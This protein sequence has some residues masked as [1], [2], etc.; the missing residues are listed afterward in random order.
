MIP[1]RALSQLGRVIADNPE[2]GRDARLRG[3]VHELARDP[4]TLVR[5]VDLIAKEARKKRPDDA[6]MEA[7]GFLLG[8]GLEVVRYGVERRSAQEVATAA[9]VRSHIAAL[10][11]KGGLAPAPVL[12]VLRRF[13]AAKL[14]LGEDLTALMAEVAAAPAPDAGAED[15]DHLFRGLAA[16]FGGDAFAIHAELAEQAAA[17]PDGQRAG[18][19]AAVLAAPDPALR[20]AAVG[21]LLDPG[22]RTRCLVGEMLGQAARSGRV[23]DVMLGRMIAIRNW[24]PRKGRAEL[25]AAI[26]AARQAGVTCRASEPVGRMD[27]LASAMD[28]SGAQTLLLPIKRPNGR[29][30]AAVLVKLDIGVRDA[31]VRSKL[32]KREMEDLLGHVAGEVGLC[33]SETAY[34]DV[35]LP[36]FLATAETSGLPPPF[37]LLGV[38]ECAG[39]GAVNPRPSPTG[40]RLGRLLDNTPAELRDRAA[41]ERALRRSAAW[42]GQW[43]FLQSWFEDDDEVAALISGRRLSAKQKIVLVVERRLQPRRARWADIMAWTAAA[44]W[45]DETAGEAWLDF[46]L[47]AGEVLGE[48]PLMEIPAMIAVAGLTVEM[49]GMGVS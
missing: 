32:P 1:I 49:A 14:D 27:V 25:D 22:P 47:V 16:T 48:R 11:R 40:E 9:A 26:L 42:G 34:L 10:A 24:V 33:Q 19:A 3:L 7:F 46:A 8:E 38:V 4:A 41:V 18:M 30:L 36:H 21:W 17:F 37:G 2:A 12:L 13:A 28:G 6:L 23:S 29:T 39:L 45:R 35:A 43:P 31:W 20:E 15:L 44:L 5:L